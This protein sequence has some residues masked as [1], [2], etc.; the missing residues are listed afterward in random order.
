MIF[1]KF[2]LGLPPIKVNIDSELFSFGFTRE[3][4]TR[5]KIKFCIHYIITR[6]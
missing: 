4:L 3:M 1:K 2:L 6:L 5:E